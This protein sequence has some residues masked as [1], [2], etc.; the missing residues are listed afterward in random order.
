MVVVEDYIEGHLLSCFLQRMSFCL[1]RQSTSI[2][3]FIS[4]LDLEVV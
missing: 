4:L 1:L 2:R 3:S